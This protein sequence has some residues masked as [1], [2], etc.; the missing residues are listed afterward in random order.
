MREAQRTKESALKLEKELFP[1]IP[2]ELNRTE[3]IRRYLDR[4]IDTLMPLVKVRREGGDCG[5]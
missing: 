3:S 2:R 1:T 5:R 4:H